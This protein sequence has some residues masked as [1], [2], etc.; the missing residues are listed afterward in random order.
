MPCRA[1]PA[2]PRLVLPKNNGS[3]EIF[4]SGSRPHSTPALVD[5][6]HRPRATG[7]GV[8]ALP[9]PRSR[10]PPPL[11]ELTRNRR[12]GARSERTGSELGASELGA[13]APCSVTPH[14][15][16]DASPPPAKRLSPKDE[17]RAAQGLIS[18][19]SLVVDV[20]VAHASLT[21][22]SLPACATR[23]GG[24]AIHGAG[25][26]TRSARRRPRRPHPLMLLRGLTQ[27]LCR[28][29]VLH[30]VLQAEEEIRRR[31]APKCGAAARGEEDR[32]CA[33]STPA[34]PYQE[35]DQLAGAS[36]GLAEPGNR[37]APSSRH[38]G[39][40]EH[41]GGTNEPDGVTVCGFVG[42][43]ICTS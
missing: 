2:V 22:A 10:R 17:S 16:V 6:P 11:S 3:L 8:V 20:P 33:R 9:R 21:L 36:Q 25:L 38:S 28:R 41:L 40:V 43:A 15:A 42:G 18:T 4:R 31:P 19:G 29:H 37:D 1:V 23:I 32:G 26:A 13:H 12:L 5:L 35:P 30:V 7:T 27:L 14:T 34:R 24:R 39:S